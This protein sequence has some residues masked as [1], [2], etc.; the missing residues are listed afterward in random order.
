MDLDSLARQIR[1]MSV[2][3]QLYKTLKAELSALGYWK[4]K[5]RGKH[6]KGQMNPKKAP[7]T[8]R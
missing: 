4:N 7:E 2:R 6:D 3:S 5:P 1:T 8:N